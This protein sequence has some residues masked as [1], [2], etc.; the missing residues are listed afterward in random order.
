VLIVYINFK[1]VN[2]IFNYSL[3]NIK[4]DEYKKPVK[5]AEAVLKAFISRQR[6]KAVRWRKS[7]GR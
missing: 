5:I 6:E 4:N 1:A 2:F 7:T 3:F